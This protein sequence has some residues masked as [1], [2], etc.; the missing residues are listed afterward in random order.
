MAIL[1]RTG[2]YGCLSLLAVVGAAFFG[3]LGVGSAHA[4][5]FS[6]TFFAINIV[7]CLLGG[8]F[9]FLYRHETHAPA[10]HTEE[11]EPIFSEP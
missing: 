5:V 11:V 8:P 4:V 6:L 9:Y 2:L 1:S 7:W 10:P 3:L